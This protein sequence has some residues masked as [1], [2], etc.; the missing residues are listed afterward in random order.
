MPIYQI[1]IPMQHINISELFKSKLF[2]IY[3]TEFRSN[4][5]TSVMFYCTVLY[6]NKYCIVL[7]FF[8]VD[9]ILYWKYVAMNVLILQSLVHVF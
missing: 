4:L 9:F 3:Q 6:N 2:R 5:Y 8:R 1:I 7:L